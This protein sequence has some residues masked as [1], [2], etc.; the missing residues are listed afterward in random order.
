MV[1]N[2]RELS[3]AIDS[4]VHVRVLVRVKTVYYR[5]CYQ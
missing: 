2:P 4:K 1:D 5:F 3:I